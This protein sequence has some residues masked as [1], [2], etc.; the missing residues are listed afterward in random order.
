MQNQVSL[1]KVYSFSGPQIILSPAPTVQAN[2]TTPL[3]ISCIAY[4][5]R[6]ATYQPT[7]FAW[8]NGLNEQIINGPQV[9]INTTTT[10][11]EG[12][13]FIESVL[14]ACQVYSDLIGQSSFLAVTC[15]RDISQA[16][17]FC[18]KVMN[19]KNFRFTQIPN[20]LVT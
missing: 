8:Y 12:H 11:I 5:G 19:H 18:R 13:V 14:S 10:V 20:K 1:L 7:S 9:T 2:W 3:R 16:H 17:N 4:L 15:E 6:E